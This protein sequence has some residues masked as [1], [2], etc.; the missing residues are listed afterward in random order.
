[1]LSWRQDSFTSS[2][3]FNSLKGLTLRRY[4]LTGI[5]PHIL[6]THWRRILHSFGKHSDKR[7]SFRRSQLCRH[8]HRGHQVSVSSDPTAE[9]VVWLIRVYLRPWYSR[10]ALLSRSFA[11]MSISKL[12]KIP[13]VIL[14]SVCC[15]VYL[16]PPSTLPDADEQA[17]YN[18]EHKLPDAVPISNVVAP[19]VYKVRLAF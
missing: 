14:V 12:A 15:Q 10:R 18:R 5:S 11:P 7:E 17:K 2:F 9:P 8:H 13:L 3:E 1:M 19:K 4:A 16:T 6:G